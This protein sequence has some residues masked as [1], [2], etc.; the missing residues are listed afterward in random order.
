MNDTKKMLTAIINGQSALKQELLT[1]IKKVKKDVA[2]HREETKVGFLKVNERIDKLGRS[3]AY[4]EDDA[5]T[6]EEISNLEERVGTL[7]KK[8]LQYNFT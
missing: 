5:P 1:E 8:S 2:D 3:L 7:E 4:L 6:M